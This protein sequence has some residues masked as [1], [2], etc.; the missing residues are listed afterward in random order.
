MDQIYSV[1]YTPQ[2]TYLALLLLR[3]P[4]SKLDTHALSL[5]PWLLHAQTLVFAKATSDRSIS[6]RGEGG[7]AGSSWRQ[8]GGKCRKCHAAN[9]TLHC[10]HCPR[11]LWP[12][13]LCPLSTVAMSGTKQAHHMHHTQTHDLENVWKCHIRKIF[14]HWSSISKR[15][16][17]SRWS[18]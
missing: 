2:A 3:Q 6:G 15:S 4:I 11:P 12:C 10:G 17:K 8:T 13:P 16:K 14:Q 1:F 9:K 18:K 5:T 7:G